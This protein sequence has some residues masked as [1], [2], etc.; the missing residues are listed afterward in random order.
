M[1][2]KILVANRSEIAIRVMRAARELGIKTA[3]VY[4]EVD[5]NALHAKYADEAYPLGGNHAKES[6]LSIKKIINIAKECGADAVHP[7]YGF[8]A[9]N[10]GFAYACEKEGIVFVGPSSKVIE[11]MG[12]KIAAR[13]AVASAGAPV[14][15][16]TT[17]EV[18]ALSE[19]QKISDEIG[20]PVIVKAAAGGGGIG[21]K[22]AQCAGE[23]EEAIGQAK[24]TAG[25]AFG[26]P[27]VFIEKYVSNPRHIEFQIL[28]DKYGNVVHLNERECSIQRRHQ[29]LIEEA[30]SP[31]MTE[32][33]RSEMGSCAVR[34]AKAI[35]YSNAGTVEFIYTNGKFYFMEMNTRIQVEHPITEMITGV[36]LLKQQIL[37][38]SGEKLSL[39][40]EDIK[41]NG[42]AIECRINAEDPLNNFAPSP[43]KLKGYRSPGGMGVRVDSGVFSSYTIPSYYDPMISKLIVW[44]GDRKEAIARMRRALYE[45]I[46]VGPKT[47]IPFHKAVLSNEAFIKGE[48]ST[49]FIAEQKTILDET[50]NIISDERTLQEKLSSI[51]KS[52]LKAA[53][54]SVAAQMYLKKRKVL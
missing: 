27:S 1:L 47:N 20:Y 39:Q 3:A 49:H 50:M 43:A 28:A 44:G 26:D 31:I 42:H 21:M 34:I 54:V 36:D 38:A 9:E 46:I 7:G 4:S 19:A 13:K 53:V 37:I 30:P 35:N 17:E 6:Y 33:L 29:K 11:L 51:F 40:Q 23:L 2:K 8:L 15:P 5:K 45:Y 10:P 12:N 14:V 24:A 52:E 18:G 32:S 25:S 41:I 16:G 48:L 22:I